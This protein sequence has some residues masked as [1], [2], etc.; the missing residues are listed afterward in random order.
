MASTPEPK[1]ADPPA[2]TGSSSATA[3]RDGRRPSR[4]R[5]MLVLSSICTALVVMAGLFTITRPTILASIVQ[6]L[7]AKATGGE[8]TIGE[9]R[10][11]GGGDVRLENVTVRVPGWAGDAAELLRAARIEATVSRSRLLAGRLL[12]KR[13]DAEA[14]V[15]RIAEREASPGRINLMDLRRPSEPVRD[16]T[17]R[18]PT[19]SL[20]EVTIEIGHLDLQE[21]WIH[22]GTLEVAAELSADLD[23]AGWLKI[24]L[25]ELTEDGGSLRVDGRFH[26]ATREHELNLDRLELDDARRDMLPLQVRAWWDRLE[27]T[28]EISGATLRV[29]DGEPIVAEVRLAKTWLTMPVETT[30]EWS[31]LRDG[32]STP[33][34][35]RPRL[36]VNSGTLRLKGLTI[37]LD[38]LSGKLIGTDP[39][40]PL[41]GIPFRIDFALPDLPPLRWEYRDDWLDEAL[42]ASAFDLTIELPE[43]A[44]A[45]GETGS[46][47][48]VELPT[49]V[50]DALA[51][52]R[53]AEWRMSTQVQVRRGAPTVVAATDGSDRTRLEPGPTT[54]AGQAY[55]N[56]ARGA[57]R[58]F[59][60][61][62]HNVTAHLSFD[63]EE[64][65]VNYLNA[66]GPTGATIAVSGRVSPP[67]PDAGVTLRVVGNAMPIDDALRGALPDGVRKAIDGLIHEPS[68]ATLRAAGL[69]FDGDQVERARERRIEIRTG[70]AAG[71]AS[72]A[73]DIETLD[74][75]IRT[76]P[77]RLGGT[78][79]IEATVTR[80][81]GRQQS[82]DVGGTVDLTDIGV[83]IDRF[84][85]PFRIVS[86]KLRLEP[87]AVHLV[88]D[89][90]RIES[91]G[92]GIGRVEG[93]I[94]MP[95]VDGRRRL[96]PD[97]RVKLA[98]DRVSSALTAAIPPTGAERASPGF[99][100]WPGAVRSRAAR[101][102]EAFGIDATLAA[103]VTIGSDQDDRL[104]WSALVDIT[105]GSARPDCS[106][107]SPLR[108]LGI[109]LPA[110]TE[111]DALV[112]QVRIAAD[113]LRFESLQAEMR[114]PDDGAEAPAAEMPDEDDSPASGRARTRPAAVEVRGVVALDREA[115]SDLAVDIAGLTLARPQLVALTPRAREVAEALWDRHRPEGT[116]D[117]TVLH[118]RPVDGREATT[119]VIE[120]HV[121]ALMVDGERMRANFRSGRILAGA[122]TV[123]LHELQLD[124]SRGDATE[125]QLR[126]DGAIAADAWTL[127]GQWHDGAFE[128]PV[129]RE[130]LH[131]LGLHDA[132]SATRNLDPV[133][134]FDATFDVAVG[135]GESQHELRIAPHT[136]AL[137]LGEHRLHATMRGS[138]AIGEQ[139]AGAIRVVPGAI[140]LDRLRADVDGAAAELDGVIDLL[141]DQDFAGGDSAGIGGGIGAS[142]RVSLDAPGLT[143][144]VR[145]LLP[146]GV[147]RTLDA[148]ELEV[149]GRLET[150]DAELRFRRDRDRWDAHLDGIIA[151]RNA[152][153]AAGLT[154]REFDG[155][156]EVSTGGSSDSPPLL[157]AAIDFD[158]FRVTGR[159]VTDGT[160]TL[161]LDERGTTLHL[162]DLQGATYGGRVE[163]H[164]SVGTSVGSAYEATVS[165]AGAGMAGISRGEAAEVED[166]DG[167]TG[168]LLTGRVDIA[169][170]LGEPSHRRGRGGLRVREGRMAEAPLT[171]RLLQVVQLML[172]LSGSLDEADISFFIDGDRLTF[173]RLELQSDTL[174]LVGTGGMKLDGLILDTRFSSR[175]TLAIFSDLMGGLTDHLFAIEVTGPLNNPRTRV[176][177]LPGLGALPSPSIA[178]G[179]GGSGA[180]GAALAPTT[181]AS[182]AAPPSPEDGTEHASR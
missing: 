5:R 154:F 88:D 98:D 32:V 37:E 141:G 148:V 113:A 51:I 82:T 101:I 179:S 33:A 109:R 43:F 159:R 103:L 123:D 161:R 139:A 128:S 119:V 117:I 93:R 157:H 3:P 107:D 112:G 150:R 74:K 12:V 162:D 87:D 41:V 81:I 4:W 57:Y 151:V 55:I 126:L 121:V 11:M 138:D 95:S 164:A 146:R 94:D 77:F 72:P 143:P 100:A 52:F 104:T 30:G 8:V 134:R 155:R 69:L 158:S 176:L 22:R 182:A 111:L 66:R 21:R 16:G 65:R 67:G 6:T 169:G 166:H 28:G 49:V 31:R 35:G 153:F 131:R 70:T 133:G 96:R 48:A 110:G 181:T 163:A 44:V 132:L 17:P 172:P 127:D 90:L 36:E 76:G 40:V 56:D 25:N 1:P 125:G 80:E 140:V 170:T 116:V 9:A 177:P 45:R 142:L 149:D 167:A 114:F 106:E 102:V 115:A 60:Y 59:D 73:D 39:M 54:I 64:V 71:A 173:E 105:S 61:P 18:F 26:P 29:K 129:I 171:L 97:L 178:P 144:G 168:G 92:G 135:A 175:G 62:L 136:L 34:A 180:G 89:G 145:A 122:D 160:A 23:R 152:T 68:E 147:R 53:L 2:V 137:N 124:L 118:E 165:V 27:L 99:D 58:K 108:A 20:P 46:L 78:I 10:W 79:D 91:I 42:A 174:R 13:L 47:P 83:V 19:L 63:N 14:V 15:L 24:S 84:P 50:A 120:P 130:I 75:M 38:Q 7:L 86:G 156:V 85:Y